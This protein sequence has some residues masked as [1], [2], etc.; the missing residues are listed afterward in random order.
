MEFT[1]PVTNSTAKLISVEAKAFVAP[2]V[3]LPN[4]LPASSAITSELAYE[5]GGE[6]YFTPSDRKGYILDQWVKW[7]V[8][9]AAAGAFLF[10][11]DVNSDNEQSYKITILDSEN[12]ELDFFEKN[13]SSGARTIQHYFNLAAGNYFVMVQN[14]T[15]HSAGHIVSMV[16]SQ[17]AGIVTIDEAATSTD[18][19]ADKVVDK[20]AD[21]PYYDVQIIRTIKAGMYNTLC[22]PFAVTST[23]CKDIFGADVQIRTLESS[24]IEEGDFVLNL[25]FKVASDIYPGTPILIQTSRDIV[26]PVFTGVKF[27]AAAPATS[28]GT[29]ANFIGNFAKGTIPASENNLFMGANNTLYFPTEDTEILGMR[30][31]FA[32]HDAPAG[33]I[34]RAR[35]V[36][37]DAP[38]VTTDIVIVKSQESGVK[39][40]KLIKD[41]QLVII[42]DGVRYNVMGTKIQ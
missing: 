31:Y 22:L 19:W 16:V 32:I 11:M 42:R 10:T 5:D 28:T 39:S 27:V 17:P 6:L 25:N 24:T 8:S 2:V 1:N 20:D 40:Q 4:T 13:P 12:N 36:E 34:Q 15:N 37:A 33:V 7:K 23:Q 9:V 14:T 26:N 41:G 21:G 38:A 30:A 3:A 18:S 35:I 29:N